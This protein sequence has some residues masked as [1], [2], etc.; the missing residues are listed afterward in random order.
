MAKTR[1]KGN[2][3][4][5]TPEN[6][7]ETPGAGAVKVVVTLVLFDVTLKAKLKA[8]SNILIL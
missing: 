3:N 6:S 5:S 7:N 8:F 4:D 2:K 1:R